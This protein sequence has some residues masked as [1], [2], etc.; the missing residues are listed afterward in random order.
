MLVSKNRMNN[1]DNI[2]RHSEVSEKAIE[3]YLAE[4]V[5]TLGG[6][7]LKYSNANM[8]GYPDRLVCLPEGKTAWVELKS[9]GKKPTKIQVLRH[10]ELTRLGHEVHVVDNKAAV[11]ELINKWRNDI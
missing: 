7:C 3:K 11:D 5:K 1:I 2:T 4:S 10:E 9:K 6:I 8:V